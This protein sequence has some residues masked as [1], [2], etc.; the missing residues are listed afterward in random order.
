M[1]SQITTAGLIEFRQDNNA[2][3]KV[4]KPHEII[5]TISLFRCRQILWPVQVLLL[6]RGVWLCLCLERFGFIH[7]DLLCRRLCLYKVRKITQNKNNHKNNFHF[8][9][10]RVGEDSFNEFCF[11]ETPDQLADSTTEY[12]V[13]CSTWRGKYEQN[14]TTGPVSRLTDSWHPIDHK[15]VPDTYYLIL[16]DM[17]S[18]KS[19]QKYFSNISNKRT[20]QLLL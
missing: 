7:L 8:F 2:F 9:C 13:P 10:H 4:I 11:A 16:T 3:T 12:I 6:Q 20:T 15:I 17:F 18:V 1:R 19:L 5:A 14:A